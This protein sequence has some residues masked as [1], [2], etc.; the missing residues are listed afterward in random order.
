MIEAVV[1]LREKSVEQ[2]MTPRTEMQTLEYTDDLEQV[3][4]FM[5]DCSHSRVPVSRDDLDHIVGL[6]YAKD[7]LKW[8]A[9]PDNEATPFKLQTILRTAT[10]VPETKTVRELL[11]EML[12]QRVH[13]ALAADEYGGTAGLV[14]IEDIVEEIFGEIHD[15]FE[16]EVAD[17][18]GISVDAA[19]GAAEADAR[20]YVHDVNDELE[21]L[22]LKLPE[23][24]DYDTLGGFIVTTMGRI[25]E[26][27]DALR[28]DGVLITIIAAEPT[29]VL[30]ARIESAP[31]EHET[32]EPAASKDAGRDAPK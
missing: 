22:G 27:G 7:L 18:P 3:K 4:A 25:P 29:R 10:F 14:T 16:P 26:V 23:D 24:E 9:E 32:P 19:L 20:A 2:I 17:E 13:I 12:A 11:V 6:L 5:R 8:L 30:R 28:T 1:E 15:E 21:A 31:P